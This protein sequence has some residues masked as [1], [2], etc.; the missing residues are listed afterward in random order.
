MCAMYAYGNP[1]GNGFNPMMMNMM[2]YGHGA[3]PPKKDLMSSKDPMVLIGGSL[4]VFML[5]KALFGDKQGLLSKLGLGGNNNQQDNNAQQQQQGAAQGFDPNAAAMN[6][7]LQDL[8]AGGIEDGDDYY[9]DDEYDDTI[10]DDDVEETEPYVDDG[11]ETAGNYAPVHFGA[12]GITGTGAGLLNSSRKAPAVL[13]AV[14]EDGATKTVGTKLDKAIHGAKNHS[15]RLKAAAERAEQASKSAVNEAEDMLSKVKAGKKSFKKKLKKAQNAVD[16]FKGDRRTSAFKNLEK[17][18]TDLKAEKSR[19][20]ASISKAE[21]AL[22]ELKQHHQKVK[23]N[24]SRVA[25]RFDEIED[26]TNQLKNTTDQVDADAIKAKIKRS[27]ADMTSEAKKATKG[28]KGT[29]IK[30]KLQAIQA[31]GKKVGVKIG[32]SRVNGILGDVADAVDDVRF[33]DDNITRASSAFDELDDVA[34]NMKKARKGLT[35]AEKA[36]LTKSGAVVDDVAKAG[37]KAGFKTFAGKALPV[38]GSVIE[39]GMAIQEFSEGDDIGGWLS[40]ISAGAGAVAA[41]TAITGIGAPIAVPAAVVSALAAG[42]NGL[43]QCFWKE[44]YMASKK[45]AQTV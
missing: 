45:A 24:S 33:V 16:N 13:R 37:L 25:K 22:D 10:V 4:V 20:K 17:K 26:L 1:Y 15:S 23:A 11:T 9:D 28:I 35:A 41:G 44:D 38:I 19:V 34:G 42:A 6:Q 43:Y 40:S 29:T 12:A 8:L 7:L 14:G 2:R 18:V 21:D 5:L 36:T 27:A 30:N 39:G 31:E 32:N 3:Q